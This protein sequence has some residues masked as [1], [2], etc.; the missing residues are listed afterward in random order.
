MESLIFTM[1]ILDTLC[2]HHWLSTI[3]YSSVDVFSLKKSVMVMGLSLCM[4]PVILR[5]RIQY[6]CDMP[7]MQQA[8]D[9]DARFVVVQLVACSS[10]FQRAQ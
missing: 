6:R 1:E 7:S 9:Y 3:D 10:T 8:Y 2:M 5:K 4:K